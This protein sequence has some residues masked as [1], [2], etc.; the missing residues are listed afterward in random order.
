MS[1]G[2][3]TV[4]GQIAK[5]TGG[6]KTGLTTLEIEVLRFVAIITTLIFSMIILVCIVWY[7]VGSIPVE[8]PFPRLTIFSL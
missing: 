6:P 3:S 8:Y 7:V 5:L 2:D 4:F 1:T